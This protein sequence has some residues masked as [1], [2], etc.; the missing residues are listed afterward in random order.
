M[1][2]RLDIER[3]KKYS[4][5][6]SD[7]VQ[8]GGRDSEDSPE[9]GRE[10]AVEKSGKHHKKSRKSRK[11]RSRSTSSSSSSSSRKAGGFPHEEAETKEDVFNKGRLGPR[12][13]SGPVDRGRPG[14]GFQL[15]IRGRGWNKGNTQGNSTNCNGPSNL[16][17]APKNEDWDPEYTP[18]SRKYFLHDDREA[19]R[20]KK[21][22]DNRGRGRGNILRGRGR[23]IVRRATINPNINRSLKWTHDKF[24]VNGTQADA[25]EEDTEQ[26]QK[27]GEQD[28]DN[29]DT[30][31]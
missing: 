31:Q 26:G 15:R 16:P 27:E 28:V 22:L 11:K 6:G 18:K 9:S 20:E 5:R 4:A 14:G 8:D 1:D 13:H 25:L 24:Q 2:L 23:F 10:R 3:R 12:E 7:C 21:W 19:E 17:M 30:M 29:K